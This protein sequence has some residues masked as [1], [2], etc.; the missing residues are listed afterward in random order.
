MAWSASAIIHTYINSDFIFS[1]VERLIS[2]TD[3]AG[4]V[5]AAGE[6]MSEVDVEYVARGSAVC[7]GYYCDESRNAVSEDRGECVV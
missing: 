3:C 7:K 6:S 1:P 5:A 2:N 4:N